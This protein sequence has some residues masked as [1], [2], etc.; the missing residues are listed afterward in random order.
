VPREERRR[1]KRVPDTSPVRYHVIGGPRHTEYQLKRAANGNISRGG[2]LLM[3]RERLEKGT[4]VEMELLLPR[5]GSDLVRH[6][7]IQGEVVRVADEPNS[8][9]E[10][11][12]GIA[13][14]GGNEEDLQAFISY[15]DHILNRL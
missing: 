2:V 3:A 5:G 10:I 15:V 7:V 9:G 8:N 6:V 13:V 11:A 1:H 12:H 4:K 14:I